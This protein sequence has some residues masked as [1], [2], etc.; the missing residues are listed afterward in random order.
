[1]WPAGD[2][3]FYNNVAVKLQGITDGTSNT[4]AVGEFARFKNDPDP[5]FNEWSRALTFASTA[6]N[7]IRPEG[8]ASS[9][10]RINA[11]FQVG[12]QTGTYSAGSWAGFPT[13][14]VDS[15][16]FLQ[17]G[18][19]FR[20]LGQFGFRSQH[21]GGANFLFADGS[22][23]FLKETIDMGN[24]NYVAPISKGVYRN[25]STRASGEVVASDAY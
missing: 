9:V 17:V 22:V 8:L 6:P 16:C 1:V 18:A 14:D 5:N 13:G 15:W 24:P 25:L 3:I 4:I 2:G 12:N 10:A 21:P 20:L 19:D 23:H 7:T 11:P